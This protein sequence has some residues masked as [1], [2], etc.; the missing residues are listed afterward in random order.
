MMCPL[1]KASD[2]DVFVRRKA[3]PVDQNKVYR[4]RDDA[5]ACARGD[6]AMALC[7]RCAFVWNQTFEAKPVVYDQDYENDQTHS[8]AF[9]DH[10]ESI[11]A[12]ILAALPQGMPLDVVEVGAGQGTFLKVLSAKA[13]NC[14]RSATGFDP[15]WRGEEGGAGALQFFRRYFGADTLALLAQPPNVIVSRHT[16]EH[17][18]DP[19][20]FLR[21]IRKAIVTAGTHIFIETPCIAWT[22]ESLAFQDFGYEH[23]SLFTKASLATA[24][25][26]AGFDVVR[27]EH[28][29]GGQYLWAEATSGSIEDAVVQPM[30]LPD[31]RRYAASEAQMKAKWRTRIADAEGVVAIWGAG[32]KGA[33]F[34]TM[35]DPQ[36]KLLT[37]AIDLNP[38]KAGTFLPG[39]GTPVVSPAEAKAR[40]VSTAIVM[41]PNY[42]G[43]IASYC[44]A[45]DFHPALIPL[46]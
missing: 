2:Y 5:R 25:K 15:A 4:S 13:G 43:E 42:V 12:R 8:P 39:V 21:H 16:I 6:M 40:G 24:M 19:L 18:V 35:I 9:R 20:A 37:C 10:V 28:V 29:F 34:A 17:V 14:F 23:C 31:T 11:A 32:G 41:N 38:N 1:C 22:V 7:R 45:M 30:G 27:I 36:G 26:K 44:A 46:K 3:V 33:T